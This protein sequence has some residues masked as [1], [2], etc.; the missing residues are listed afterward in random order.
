MQGFS[1]ARR[2]PR[3]ALLGVASA[4]LLA[5]T[6]CSSASSTKGASVDSGSTKGAASGSA[7][8]VPSKGVLTMWTFKLSEVSALNAVAAAWSKTSGYT[9]KV[10][11]FQPEPYNTKVSAAVKTHTLPDILSVNSQGLEWSYAE[12]GVL[13]DIT[14]QFTP[15]WQ[16]RFLPGVVSSTTLTADRIKNSGT[17]P[18][19]TLKNL[20]PDH[21]YAVPYLA[22]TPG[23]V[24]ARKSAMQ[25]AGLDPTPPSTWEQWVSDIKATTKA[26]PASGGVV[27]GLKNPATGYMWLYRP[28]SFAYLGSDAFYG[29]EGVNHTPDWNSPQSKHTLDL[30]DQLT[31][32]WTPGVL[33]LDIDPADQTFAQGKAAWDVGG[34][35][36]L[37]SLQAFGGDPSDYM[38]FPVPAPQ[39]G[40]LSK[41]EYQASP[42]ISGGVTT[43]SKHTAQALSFLDFLTSQTG[44]AIFAKTANDL[45]ATALPASSDESPLLRQLLDLL[46]PEASP[47]V[48][49][50]NDFSADPAAGN[51]PVVMNAA[52]AINQLVAKTKSASQV[53]DQLASMF[54][55][56]WTAAKK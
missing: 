26:D 10:T 9:V 33:N 45:P 50:P 47:S 7:E 13:Q 40:A 2:S 38:A 24:F 36:T 11:A 21:F 34:T 27:T 42:L 41:L 54:Q 55:Q 6:A 43:S 25:A 49:S 4:T 17:D 46:A 30:Y 44:A 31:P 14:T 1:H 3:A 52:N 19:T 8:A 22:G 5:V 53:A 51:S 20:T 39:G 56:A 32:L 48:F 23:V 15:S 35:F 29:R 16:S 28:M 12:A 18:T 37:S